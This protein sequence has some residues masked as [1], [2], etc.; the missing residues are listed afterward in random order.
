MLKVALLLVGATCVSAIIKGYEAGPNDYPF[1]V[2]VLLSKE[3]QSEW[4][5]GALIHPRWVLT[6]ATCMKRTPQASVMT[7]A[8][9][10]SSPVEVMPV[11]EIKI[12]P[13]FS[14]FFQSWDYALLRLQR[15]VKIN[16]KIFKKPL[17]K[18]I[19]KHFRFYRTSTTNSFTKLGS[20]EENIQKCNRYY[21]WLGS[22]WQE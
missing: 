6:S 9:T 15:A 17:K 3:K 12:H 16:G 7:G 21:K 4:C 2:G 10:I 14:G 11:A 18:N 20:K 1:Q 13:K 19:Y 5:G 8:S 22:R